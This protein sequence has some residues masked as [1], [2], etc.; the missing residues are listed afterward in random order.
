MLEG[1]T[2]NFSLHFI[3]VIIFMLGNG[4]YPVTCQWHHTGKLRGC[5]LFL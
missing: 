2:E 5:R 4:I 1:E 3:H